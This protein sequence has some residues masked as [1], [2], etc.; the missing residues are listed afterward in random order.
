MSF[1]NLVYN[2]DPPERRDGYFRQ[3]LI[4]CPDRATSDLF[5]RYI[6]DQLELSEKAHFKE[7]RRL[8]P[9]IWTWAGKNN[10]YEIEYACEAVNLG[11]AKG[12]RQHLEKLQGRVFMR[13]LANANTLTIGPAILPRLE[14]LADHISGNVF[15]I[16]NQRVP[17]RYWLKPDVTNNNPG[18]KP[19]QPSNDQRSRFK[20]EVSKQHQPGTLMVEDD[21]VRMFLV[22]DNVDYLIKK[23]KD[24]RLTTNEGDEPFVFRFG[25]LLNGGFLSEYASD[26]QKYIWYTPGDEKSSLSGEI[27]ELC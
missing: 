13:S 25:R 9:Q 1:Y 20:I 18:K 3:A 27:W 10:T 6:Q 12:R 14:D 23:A 8:S 15:C 16:R 11:Y 4:V 19:V 21:D 26:K 17:D 5:F 24:G 22:H 2:Q 7:L